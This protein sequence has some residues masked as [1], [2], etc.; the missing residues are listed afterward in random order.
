MINFTYFL[1]AFNIGA[2]YLER[3]ILF[4]KLARPMRKKSMSENNPR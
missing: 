2:Y 1:R 4:S 3:L